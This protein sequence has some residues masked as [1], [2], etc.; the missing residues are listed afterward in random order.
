MSTYICKSVLSILNLLFSH[1]IW[2][3]YLSPIS[4]FLQLNMD[5]DSSAPVITYR[6]GPDMITLSLPV[7]MEFPLEKQQIM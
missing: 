6:N 5:T 3:Q 1:S 4:C 2:L 7:G